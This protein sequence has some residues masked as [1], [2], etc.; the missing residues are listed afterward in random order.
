MNT[1]AKINARP[2]VIVAILVII[3]GHGLHRGGVGRFVQMGGQFQRLGFEAVYEGLDCQPVWA[4]VNRFDKNKNKIE[5]DGQ[6]MNVVCCC[7]CIE[8][9]V[10]LH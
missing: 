8:R 4:S 9:C 10:R 7:V 6:A 3:S 5:G 2:K 1:A